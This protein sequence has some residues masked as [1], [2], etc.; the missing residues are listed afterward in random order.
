MGISTS[1]INVQRPRG[2]V[3]CHR[4]IGFFGKFRRKKGSDL[5]R[6]E[7]K[8]DKSHESGEHRRKKKTRKD[9]NHNFTFRTLISYNRG[10]PKDDE[11]RRWRKTQGRSL[12]P[13]I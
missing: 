13:A 8:A 2:S 10:C 12:E 6:D 3:L 7:T 1:A 9:H 4:L 5:G 11:F